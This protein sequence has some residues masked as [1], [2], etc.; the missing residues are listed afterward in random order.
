MYIPERSHSFDSGSS[1]KQSRK[2]VLMCPHEDCLY[3]AQAVFSAR[4]DVTKYLRDVHD[5]SLF[6]CEFPGC[7]KIGGK[8]FFREEAFIKH[9]KEHEEAMMA[10]DEF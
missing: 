4:R 6:P 5:E 10:E 2:L 1:S 8:G 3:H 9:M 7:R